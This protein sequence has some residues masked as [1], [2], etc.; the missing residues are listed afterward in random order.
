MLRWFLLDHLLMIIIF[1]MMATVIS[2]L[3]IH[4]RSEFIHDRTQ[5]QNSFH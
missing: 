3:F 4:T 5:L 2:V 1:I